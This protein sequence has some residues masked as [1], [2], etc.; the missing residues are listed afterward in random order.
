MENVFQNIP[1]S[2]SQFQNFPLF[3][4]NSNMGPPCPPSYHSV[5]MTP[6][7]CYTASP[8]NHE[9]PTYNNFPNYPPPPINPSFYPVGPNSEPGNYFG[10]PPSWH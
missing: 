2:N 8:Y 7:P 1:S 10:N 5:P 9:L 6:Y 4:T 3:Q